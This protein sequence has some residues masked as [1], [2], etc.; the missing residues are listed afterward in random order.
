[1]STA[2]TVRRGLVTQFGLT[3]R[4]ET[5]SSR[6]GGPRQTPEQRAYLATSFS[7]FWNAADRIFSLARDG[8]QDEA[9]AQIELSLQARQAALSTAVARLLVQN[10]E[11]EEQTAQQ[12]QDIY[13]QVQ[14]QVYWFL[15]AT[16]GATWQPACTVDQS[17]A[18]RGWRCLG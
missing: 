8:Q 11:A 5:P 9:R 18:V 2:T 3:T 17:A 14:R 7:Q 16:L 12:V 10:N 13:L 4:S 15:A 6:R 1:M